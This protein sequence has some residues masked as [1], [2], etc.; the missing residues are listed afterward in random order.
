MKHALAKKNRDI[1]LKQMDKQSDK[2]GTFMG[3][4]IK[5]Y[6]SDGKPVYE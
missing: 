5:W 6:T 4:K 1:L 3:K 2:L